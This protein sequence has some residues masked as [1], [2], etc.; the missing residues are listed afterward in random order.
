M[1]ATG[2]RRATQWAPRENVRKAVSIAGTKSSIINPIRTKACGNRRVTET[3]EHMEWI[4][5]KKKSQ[6]QH[7][8]KWSTR[9]HIQG[10]LKQ[11]LPN[12]RPVL[13]SDPM[14]VSLEITNIF[15]NFWNLQLGETSRI[16]EKTIGTI[17]SSNTKINWRRQLF[18]GPNFHLWWTKYQLQMASKAF[19][20]RH[21]SIS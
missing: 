8:S 14:L 2:I 5:N 20:R 6:K 7:S 21:G 16:D 1:G 13:F 15:T 19:V 4:S 3:T 11:T 17:S 10:G 18:H 9:Y 12:P